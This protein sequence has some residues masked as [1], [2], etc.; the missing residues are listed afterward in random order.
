MSRAVAVVA[1]AMLTQRWRLRPA[2][3]ASRFAQP[4]A[5]AVALTRRGYAVGLL[6]G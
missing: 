4:L 3:G 2:H 1:A 5:E 6:A